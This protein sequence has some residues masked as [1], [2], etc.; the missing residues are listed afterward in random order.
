MGE[1]ENKS[2]LSIDMRTHIFPMFGTSFSQGRCVVP[3]PLAP[4][5]LEYQQAILFAEVLQNLGP[6]LF[7]ATQNIVCIFN[8][9]A[10]SRP[11]RL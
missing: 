1:Q 9:N 4:H 8:G 5:P 11:K 10:K 3:R 7:F 6:D 2:K